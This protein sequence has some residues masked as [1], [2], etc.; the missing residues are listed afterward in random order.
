MPRSAVRPFAARPARGFTLIELLVVIAIIAILIGLLLPAVQKVREAAAR[1]KCANNLKQLGLA[2]HNHEGALGAFPALGDYQSFGSAVYWSVQARLLPYCEQENLQKL[3]DFARP[4]AVQPQVAKVRVPYLLCPSEPNDRE[5]PDGPTF[6][7]YPLNYGANAGL[8][9]LY[10]PPVGRSEGAFVLNRAMR[11]ADFADGLSN[12]LGFA[13]V[14]AF[15]PYWRDGGVPAAP[16][17]PVPATPAEVTAHFTAGEFKTDSG[18]TEWVDA[19]AHQTGFTTTFPPNTKVPF[20]F[21]GTTYD[22]DFNSL[23][24]GRSTTLPTY[25]AVTSRSH[26]SGGV[27]VL[28]MDGSVRFATSGTAQA[29]WRALGTRAGGEVV[30][31]F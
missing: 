13:E 18:H 26:H 31:D 10:Q 29:T 9:H 22:A 2:L 5:R 24:E 4:I 27:N 28:L 15:T 11:G 30:S 14:K 6:T 25:A 23:R 1:L 17:A 20:A 12:T 19:R 21:N 8:W 3:I 16:G 7:H